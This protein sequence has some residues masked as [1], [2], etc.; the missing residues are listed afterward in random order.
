MDTATEKR[1]GAIWKEES[2]LQE[3]IEQVTE[4]VVQLEKRLSPILRPHEPT[5]PA[6]EGAKQPPEERLPDLVGRL[7][8]RVGGVRDIQ[9][10]LGSLLSRLEI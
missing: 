4:K 3:L 8:A 9:S 2:T 1:N 10:H 5:T 7:H 6:A